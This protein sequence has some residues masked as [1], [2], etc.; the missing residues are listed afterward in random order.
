MFRGQGAFTQVWFGFSRTNLLLRL[1]PAKGVDLTGELRVLLALDGGEKTVRMR[2]IAGGA[3]G[4]A[5]D[6]KG[7]RVGSGRTGTIV[8]LS[9]ARDALALKPGARVSLLFRM[10]RDEVEV[11]RL[12]RYGEIALTVPDRNFE[13]ANWRV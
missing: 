6:D 1:D 5:I 10:L 3:E 8:E 4:D 9:L 11:D 7:A 2:L 13:L 12:P